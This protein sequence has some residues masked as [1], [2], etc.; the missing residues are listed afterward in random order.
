LQ[1]L[2]RHIGALHR[3]LQPARHLHRPALV[4]EIPLDLPHDGGRGERR[5]LQA[6]LRLEA[7]DR[8]Q[9]SDIADLDDILQRLA[10]VAEFLGQEDHQIVEQLDKLLADLRIL[11]LLISKEETANELTVRSDGGLRGGWAFYSIRYLTI[12]IRML[13]V[14]SSTW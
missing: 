4:P 14:W 10:P 5:K 1:S 2:L 12:L 13:P 11:R 8:L 7:L 9:Q 3:L 6:P